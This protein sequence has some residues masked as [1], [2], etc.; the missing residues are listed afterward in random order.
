MK[1]GL[2]LKCGSREIYRRGPDNYGTNEKIVVKAGFV[3]K[4]AAPDKYVCLGCGYLESY[5]P[6]EENAEMVREHWQ[7]VAE[8]S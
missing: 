2:C 7:R 3:T 6:L 5:L 1:N 8:P 4:G